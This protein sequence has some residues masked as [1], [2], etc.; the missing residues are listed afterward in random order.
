[1]RMIPGQVG[2]GA[3]RAEIQI[4]NLLR[5]LEVPG[6]TYAFHSFNLPEHQRKRVCEID[7]L[8]LGE[9]GLLVLEAKGGRV[10][11]RRR[12]L[13]HARSSRCVT[14]AKGEPV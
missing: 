13:A 8:L 6:W 11:R 1:M 14:P 5:A 10:T 3:S 7:F 2:P 9:R 4:F 12:C